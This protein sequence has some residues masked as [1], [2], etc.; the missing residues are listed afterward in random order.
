MGDVKGPAVVVTFRY[1]MSYRWLR[2]ID[3][4]ASITKIDEYWVNNVTLNLK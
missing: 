4:V 1:I 2:L 3:V